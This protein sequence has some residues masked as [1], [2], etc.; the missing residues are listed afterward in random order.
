[1]DGLAVLLL[2]QILQNSDLRELLN[3]ENEDARVSDHYTRQRLYRL[4]TL[5]MMKDRRMGQER[6]I[7]AK[8]TDAVSCCRLT[9]DDLATHTRRTT[10]YE[11][12]D[13]GKWRRNINID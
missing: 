1:L 13:E 7:V 8:H 3:G 2:D 4:A 9:R 6:R 12:I 5:A 11:E 10:G